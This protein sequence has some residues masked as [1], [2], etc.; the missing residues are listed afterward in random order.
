M[1]DWAYM[2]ADLVKQLVK[3]ARNTRSK[4]GTPLFV[5]LSHLYAKHELLKPEEQEMYEELLDI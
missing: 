3:I 4:A 5:Y 2:M 1:V